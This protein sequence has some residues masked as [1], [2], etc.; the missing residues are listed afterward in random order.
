MKTCEKFDN[1]ADIV[2]SCVFI[3]FLQR[4]Y[5]SLTKKLQCDMENCEDILIENS[6]RIGEAGPRFAWSASHAVFAFGSMAY[7]ALR[8]EPI[9]E[10]DIA[11]YRR[12]D[13]QNTPYI[14]S[15]RIAAKG[16]TEE[17]VAAT[18]RN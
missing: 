11:E 16:A 17:N 14:P 15:P 7:P 8:G 18:Q 6:G 3:A 12:A 13:G 4:R 9:N 1:I 5:Q 10:E 2:F